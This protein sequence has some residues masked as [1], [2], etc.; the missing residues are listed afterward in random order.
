MAASQTVPVPIIESLA[1]QQ[2]NISQNKI[3]TN[4][5]MGHFMI[6]DGHFG[7]HFH[8]KPVKCLTHLKKVSGPKT[9]TMF[10]QLVHVTVHLYNKNAATIKAPPPSVF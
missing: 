10:K 8:L 1:I 6:H 4:N 3:H 5:T 9:K 7:F 2:Q